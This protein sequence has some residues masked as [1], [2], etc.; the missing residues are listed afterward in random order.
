MLFPHLAI[1]GARKVLAA[2]GK[3]TAIGAVANIT[4]RAVDAAGARSIDSYLWDRELHG[5]GL[6][7]TPAQYQLGDEKGGRAASPSRGMGR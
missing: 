2:V 4:K 1:G 7:V 3:G 5:F 6:K